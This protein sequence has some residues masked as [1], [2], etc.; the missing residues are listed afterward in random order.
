MSLQRLRTALSRAEFTPHTLHFAADFDLMA[1]LSPAAREFVE[2]LWPQPKLGALLSS[3]PWDA[4]TLR[5]FR[6][7][8]PDDRTQVLALTGF[9]NHEMV[10][11]IDFLTTPFGAAFQG[12]ACLE[13]IGLLLESAELVAEFERRHPHR[14][15]RDI[16]PL[17]EKLVVSDGIEALNARVRWFDSLRGAAPKYV[18]AGWMNAPRTLE[19]GNAR[20]DLVMVHELMPTVA[21][22]GGEGAYLRPLTVLESRA[23]ALTGQLL[24]NRLGRDAFATEEIARLLEAFYSPREAFPD[25]RFLLDLYGELL[26]TDDFFA[27]VREQG[28]EGLS[29]AFQSMAVLGWYGLHASPETNSDAPL[30]SSPM[31]R[32]VIALQE[33]IALLRSGNRELDAVAFLNEID[34]ADRTAEFRLT[35]STATLG[36]SILYLRKVRQHNYFANPHEGLRT[37]FESVLST[38]QRQLERRY[39]EGYAFSPGMSESGSAIAGL[40]ADAEDAQL[41]FDDDEPPAPVRQWFRLREMLLFRHARPPDFWPGLW[42]ALGTNPGAEHASLD[43]ARQLALARARFVANGFWPLEI[44]LQ[45]ANDGKPLAMI[46]VRTSTLPETFRKSQQQEQ[47]TVETRWQVLGTH[48]EQ[49]VAL[50]VG[51]ADADEEVRILFS[52]ERH[53]AAVEAIVESERVVLLSEEAVAAMGRNEQPA[54]LVMVPVTAA[55]NVVEVALAGNVSVRFNQHEWGWSATLLRDELEA[56]ELAAEAYAWPTEDLAQQVLSKLE[57]APPR[58]LL[59]V[60]SARLPEADGR[61]LLIAVGEGGAVRKLREEVVRGSGATAVPLSRAEAEELI[62]GFQR[63]VGE[64]ASEDP[65]LPYRIL[66]PQPRPVRLD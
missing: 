32:L 2:R 20:L 43:A 10:H 54:G 13:T 4:D 28:P 29:A 44:R 14:P 34:T 11:R 49:L 21:I 59:T 48:G 7:L 40:G 60:H 31:L 39:E 52:T 37:H 35:D 50:T 24:L 17:A 9:Y 25:Y 47:D 27:L 23:V 8:D 38:Q 58:P 6:A 26:G 1:A 33:F 66:E 30:N 61:R 3:D 16:P 56:V 22:P 57:G 64:A 62:S 42:S 53:R 36:Y 55:P 12:K 63:K 18:E 46:P 41:L 19:V 15:L 45:Q 65:A 51:F 5:R